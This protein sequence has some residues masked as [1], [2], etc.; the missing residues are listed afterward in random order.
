MLHASEAKV[1]NQARTYKNIKSDC[2]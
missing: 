2:G 1:H